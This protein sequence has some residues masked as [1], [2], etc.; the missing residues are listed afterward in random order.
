MTQGQSLRIEKSHAMALP[1][2]PGLST[3]TR[4]TFFSLYMSA[5]PATIECN[6]GSSLLQGIPPK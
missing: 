3:Q 2:I 5:F 6:A 4:C 1:P